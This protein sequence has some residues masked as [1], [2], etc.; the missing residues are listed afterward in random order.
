MLH[1]LGEDKGELCQF[2]NIQNRVDLRKCWPKNTVYFIVAVLFN[3]NQPFAITI[4]KGLGSLESMFLMM[5]TF[6]I[7]RVVSTKGSLPKNK[8]KIYD[9][10][11]MG[12]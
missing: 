3:E 4:S 9:I 11:K 8:T 6:W 7:H 12:G 1:G 2:S 5:T 10:V